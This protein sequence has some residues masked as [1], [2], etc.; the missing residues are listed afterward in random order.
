LAATIPWANG[1][2][3]RRA[4]TERKKARKQ[5]RNAF[6]QLSPYISTCTHYHRADVIKEPI[7][8]IAYE[9]FANGKEEKGEGVTFF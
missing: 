4:L 6:E 2:E 5:L 1:D 9:K 7:F 3:S 8:E